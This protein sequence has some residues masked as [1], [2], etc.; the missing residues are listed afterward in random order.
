MR[1]DANDV[2]F[3]RHTEEQVLL[4]ALGTYQMKLA[5]SYCSEHLQ[6]GIYTIEVYRQNA[7]EDL[8]QYGINEASWLLRGRIQ[9]RHIRAR[10]YYCYI[11]IN[12]N[13]NTIS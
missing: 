1:L 3:P 12:T 11:I 6:N 13:N 5:K 2:Q 8:P 9:S 10:I 4:L 7:L